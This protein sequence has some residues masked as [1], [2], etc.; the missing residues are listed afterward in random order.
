MSELLSA[1]AAALGTPEALVKRAAEARAAASGASVDEVLTAWAG[2]GDIPTTEETPSEVPEEAGP[3]D[4]EADP[5]PADAPAE[6]PPTSPEVVIEM[7]EPTTGPIEEVPDGPYKPPILVGAADNPMAV[8]AGVIGLFLVIL[9][10]GLIGPALPSDNP[11]ARTSS[12]AFSDAAQRGQSIYMSIGCAACHTQMVRP[13]VADVGLGP[14]T[15]NDTNQ[16]LGTRRYGPD[17]SD[18]GSR[19]TISEMES[20]VRGASVHPPY[21]LSDA[22][23]ARLLAYL[24][25]SRT[26]RGAAG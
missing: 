16:V 24:S 1:A 15:L 18:I 11:G 19:A 23:M 8:F 20:I 4:E 25:E 26:S 9:L 5:T 21:R 7:P 13:V 6:S 14:V 12:V 22:D 17:L 10:V 2:G 3:A